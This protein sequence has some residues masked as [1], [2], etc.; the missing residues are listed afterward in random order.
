MRNDGNGE[1]NNSAQSSF[2]LP[3]TGYIRL[4]DVLKLFPVSRSTY[5]AGVK[6]G[7]YPKPYRLGPN[8]AGYKVEEIKAFLE[9][10]SHENGGEPL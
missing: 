9:S 1:S 3:S 7:R 10:F 5:M 8:I 2:I 4:K 6:E